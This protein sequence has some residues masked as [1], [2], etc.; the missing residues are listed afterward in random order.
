MKKFCVFLLFIVFGLPAKTQNLRV[1]LSTDSICS[2]QAVTAT[3]KGP[4]LEL[5]TPLSGTIKQHGIIFD[6][7]AKHDA[8]I[9]G[10]KAKVVSSNSKLRVYYRPGSFV[11][12]ENSAAGWTLLDTSSN[13]SSGVVDIGVNLSLPIQA[14]QT[15]A[16][17]ITTT[18]IGSLHMINYDWGSSVGKT[19]ASDS[20]LIVKEGVGKSYPFGAT[21]R[22]RNF[23]GSILYEP[24]LS[25]ISWN[26]GNDT[27]NS[28]TFTPVRTV[29][30]VATA[31]HSGSPTSYFGHKNLNV[32]KLDVKASA[33][34]RI[35]FPGDTSILHSNVTGSFGLISTFRGGNLQNGA[36]FDLVGIKP[37]KITGFS[38]S[39][40]DSGYTEME[41][42]M[43]PGSFIG[44]ETD[45]TAWN[46]IAVYSGIAK[47]QSIYLALPQ[48]Q[49]ILSGDTVSFYITTTDGS[50][51]QYSN[52]TAIGNDFAMNDYFIIKEGVGKSY[53]FDYTYSPRMLN[54]VVHY[55]VVDPFGTNY[56]WFP[57]GVSGRSVNVTPTSTQIYTLTA[58]VNGCPETDTA[59]VTVGFV[60]L[61]E[62]IANN[63]SVYPNP[64]SNFLRI[65]MNEIA[66]NVDITLSDLHGR[67]VYKKHIN[68]LD[69]SNDIE[70]KNIAPGLYLLQVQYDGRIANYKIQKL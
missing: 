53:P 4:G 23:M 55:E 26:V 67:I 57:G 36:M 34:P 21:F 56:S 9:K 62:N 25:K 24:M 27:T 68:T 64:A 18:G 29:G 46:R 5:E 58:D 13:I 39:V 65:K 54:M 33:A 42:F 8:I 38:V 1:S 35:I 19:L 22:T 28:I 50:V 20:V 48:P 6:V 63:I 32:S 15:L 52:G 30:V 7:T 14:G 47:G 11:G 12:Y 43:K 66:I 16:F 61:N 69:N 44:F 31:Y 51:V 40:V 17:Y 41:I 49:S 10:F 59:I 2:G 70:L 37:F 45:S 60:G 3:V